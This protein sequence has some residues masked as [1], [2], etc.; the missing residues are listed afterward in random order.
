MK[1]CVRLL[2]LI[3]SIFTLPCPLYSFDGPLQ[4]KNQ[5]PVFLH[6]GQ[7]YMEKASPE[8]SFSVGISHSSTYTVDSSGTWLVSLD[9]EITELN[10]RYKRLIGD[11]VEV[12]LDVPV[13]WFSDGFLDGFLESYHDAF[14]FPDY[15]RKERPNN[16]FLYEVR[17]N[18]VLLINSETGAGLGDIRF[19]LKKPLI[20]ESSFALAVKADLEL[21]TGNSIKGYGNGNVDGGISILIDRNIGNRVMTH[22]NLGVIFPGDVNAYRKIDLD[23]FIFGGGAIEVEAGSKFSVLAQVQAQSSIY[24]ETDLD[25]VDSPAYLLAIGGRYDTGDDVFELSLTEDLS[26][27]GAPDFIINLTYKRRL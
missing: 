11:A 19:T 4:V 23:N 10:L 15:G 26:E 9:M 5:Y 25:A 24:P 8:N 6:A 17:R 20:S 13:I 2:I 18:D 1:I 22:W 21:P 3:I 14:N 27:S 7:P 16:E 12:G